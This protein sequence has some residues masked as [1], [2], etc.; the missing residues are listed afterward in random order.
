MKLTETQ[1]LIM[2]RLIEAIET[3]D[4]MPGR[5]G[6][7]QFGSAMPET[8]LSDKE[9]WVLEFEDLREKMRFRTR[10]RWDHGNRQAERRSKCTP[11]RISRMEETLGWVIQWLWDTDVRQCLLG[12]ATVRARGWDWNRFVTSRN[13]RNRN[14]KAW[15]RQTTYRW[16]SKSLQILEQHLSKNGV[17]LRETE[18][19]G[20]RQIRAENH[21]KFDIIGFVRADAA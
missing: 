4:A 5:T 20:V 12:F 1:A 15:V 16:I 14:K 7:R 17:S 10:Q 13:R 3:D 18:D 8:A 11:A 19:C 2:E 21:H 6:P 9:I